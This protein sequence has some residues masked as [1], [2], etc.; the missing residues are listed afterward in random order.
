MPSDKRPPPGPNCIPSPQSLSHKQLGAISAVL[1]HPLRQVVRWCLATRSCCRLLVSSFLHQCTVH[2]RS[3]DE[4]RGLASQPSKIRQC[5]DPLTVQPFAGAPSRKQRELRTPLHV[6]A[7]HDF[8]AGMP[9][10]RTPHAVSDVSG[11][12]IV[13]I[14]P[15]KLLRSWLTSDGSQTARFPSFK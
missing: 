12:E 8:Q 5:T 14:S 3:E 13:Q 11:S 1:T 9:R 2:A 4:Q 6:P 7:V 10:C 15:P